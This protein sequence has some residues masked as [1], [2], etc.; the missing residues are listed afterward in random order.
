MTKTRLNFHLS[1]DFFTPV[2]KYTN[3]QKNGAKVFFHRCSFVYPFCKKNVFVARIHGYTLQNDHCLFVY[4]FFLFVA[5]INLLLGTSIRPCLGPV[6]I[7]RL[8]KIAPL[9]FLPAP[10]VLLHS[11]YIY[12]LILW[13]PWSSRFVFWISHGNGLWRRV[14]LWC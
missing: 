7:R 13:F 1:C 4:L 2:R 14:W 6:Q 11:S 9:S 12:P 3:T 8:Q 10:A 5:Q